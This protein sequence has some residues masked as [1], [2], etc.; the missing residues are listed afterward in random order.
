RLPS[1]RFSGLPSGF[2]EGSCFFYAPYVF[3][4]APHHTTRHGKKLYGKKLPSVPR[5]RFLRVGNFFPPR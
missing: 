5:V 2:H 1:L 4:I 3:T